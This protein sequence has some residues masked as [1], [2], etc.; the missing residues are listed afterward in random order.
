MT[1]QS[2][3]P[4]PPQVRRFRLAVLASH[5]IQYQGPLFRW[6]AQDPEIDLTVFYCSDQGLRS[7]HDAG[8][9]HTVRWDVPLLDGYRSEFLPNWKPHGNPSRVLGSLNPSLVGRLR[10]GH[11]DALWIHGWSSAMNWLAMAAACATRTPVL[12]RGETNLMTGASHTAFAPLRRAILTRLFQRVAAFLSIGR[13]NTEFYRAFGV[14]A[15]KIFP[16]PYAINNE[17]FLSARRELSHR[18]RELKRQIGVGED[19]PVVLFSGKLI[20]NKSP[21][22]LL[23]AFEI[24][25]RRRRASLVF[26]GDGFLRRE[27]EEYAAAAGLRDV[28][29]AGFRNQ[30]EIAGY[31]CAADV[32]VLPSRHEPWG[33][34]VNEAM[35]FGLPVIASDRVGAGGD[36]VHDGKNGFVFPAGDTAALAD[37]LDRVLADDMLREKM[38][39]E[40][41]RQIKSWSYEQDLAGLKS[42]LRFVAGR[43]RAM[44]EPV[45]SVDERPIGA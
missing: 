37:R 6:I 3:G 5:V 31:F 26:L 8:F 2:A 44:T 4:A 1:G 41:E 19:V 14:P 10:R 25:S 45:F 43:A 23:R 12:M 42:A 34:V 22:D 20:E 28:V 16:V 39:R 7:Y 40:S 18:K 24:V 33:L 27:L 21:M 35:C 13:Y 9:G 11:Y 38:G 32:F 36:L 15:D 30:S 29:F 17:H